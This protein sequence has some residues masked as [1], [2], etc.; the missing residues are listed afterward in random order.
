MRER[1]TDLQCEACLFL[2]VFGAALPSGVYSRTI[3]KHLNRYRFSNTKIPFACT[4]TAIGSAELLVQNEGS[5]Y[6]ALR[7][8]MA[9]LGL[10]KPKKKGGK[11]IADVG[12]LNNLPVSVAKEASGTFVVA[13]DLS[14][15]S[16]ASSFSTSNSILGVMDEYRADLILQREIAAADVL[17]SP[18]MT[19]SIDLM[20][21]SSC[22]D[23]M[24]ESYEETLGCDLNGV[25]L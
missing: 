2:N 24:N 17:I 8:S 1:E 23:I 5:I 11:A 13:V 6:E 18:V 16:G 20:D 4:S 22:I 10:F 9:I 7:V 19:R 14:S 15:M 12:I 3:R 25:T 21:F